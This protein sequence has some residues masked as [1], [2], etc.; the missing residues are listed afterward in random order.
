MFG[1]KGIGGAKIPLQGWFVTRELK[2]IL[3]PPFPLLP[4]K[5]LGEGH[6]ISWY[7]LGNTF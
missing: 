2:G 7:A 3:A 1:S 4:N 5:P 6:S